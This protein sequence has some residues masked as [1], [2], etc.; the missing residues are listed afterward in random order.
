MSVVNKGHNTY[1][2][3]ASIWTAADTAFV[4]QNLQAFEQNKDSVVRSSGLK[5]LIVV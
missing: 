3:A 2:Q 5:D 4:K 1:R